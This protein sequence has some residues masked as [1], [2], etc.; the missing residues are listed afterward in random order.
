VLVQVVLLLLIAV[1]GVVAGGAWTGPLATLTAVL[2]LVLMVAGALLLGRGLLDLGHSLTPLPYPRDDAQLVER[3]I[4]ALARHPIYGGLIV[5][6][7]GWGLLTASLAGMILAAG[8]AAFFGL[9]SRR[10]EQWLRE[11]FPGYAEYASR[12]KRFIPWLY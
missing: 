12:T 1:C 6:A 9:K 5:T 4:Y 7:T 11:R 10:E 3:G 8:L 2:G